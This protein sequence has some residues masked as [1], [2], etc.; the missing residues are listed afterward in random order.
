MKMK[1]IWI[2]VLIIIIITVILITLSS[3]FNTTKKEIKTEKAEFQL[4]AN[5]LLAEFEQ[6]EELANKKYVSKI[7]EVKGEIGEI[8]KDNDNTFVIIL[9]EKDDMFG[10][11]CMVPD[12]KIKINSYIVG[13]SIGIKGIVQGYLND[14]IINNCIIIK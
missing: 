12:K 3:V 6:D 8:I 11:N 5:N 14:V 10:I 7:I 1:K 2:L 13:D 9:K 4:Y